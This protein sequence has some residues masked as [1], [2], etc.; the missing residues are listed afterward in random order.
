MRLPVDEMEDFSPLENRDGGKGR[1]QFGSIL[2]RERGIFGGEDE[3]NSNL[4]IVVETENKVSGYFVQ[5][6]WRC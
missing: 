5:S 6:G 4:G 1:S 3:K 2:R